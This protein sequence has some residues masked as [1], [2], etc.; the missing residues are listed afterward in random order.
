MSLRRWSGG[1]EV[2]LPFFLCVCEGESRTCW[3]RADAL[4]NDRP[5][6]DGQGC[7]A[8]VASW[9]GASRVCWD[10]AEAVRKVRPHVLQGWVVEALLVVGVVVCRWGPAG[11]VVVV[12]LGRGAETV[13]WLGESFTCLARAA[14]LG[15]GV[16]QGWQV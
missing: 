4:P 13:V 16:L 6:Q 10:R 3:A 12:D 7:V 2:V 14:E 1:G 15:N 5:E 8:V 11:D 9:F